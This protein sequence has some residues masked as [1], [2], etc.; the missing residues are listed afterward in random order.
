MRTK[1]RRSK[2][3]E[4]LVPL[5]CE[6]RASALSQVWVVEGKGGLCIP[7]SEVPL[8]T[9]TM[10]LV[11]GHHQPAEIPP[12]RTAAEEE[13]NMPPAFPSPTLDLLLG[14]SIGQPE[15]RPESPWV[16]LVQSL[17]EGGVRCFYWIISLTVLFTLEGYSFL[18]CEFFIFQENFH[19]ITFTDFYDFGKWMQLRKPHQN[20][21]TTIYSFN[22]W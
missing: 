17:P 10:T 1:Y 5:G 3:A 14:L 13:I 19:S 16:Q 18:E 22:Y 7:H 21:N 15:T 6:Q 12:E 20:K 11:Q 8:E 2:K 9:G 4:E